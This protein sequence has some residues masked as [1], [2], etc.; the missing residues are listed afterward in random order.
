[1]EQSHFSYICKELCWRLSEVHGHTEP[2][3]GW[4]KLA[5]NYLGHASSVAVECEKRRTATWCA[6]LCATY[7]RIVSV[8]ISV[9]I[10]CVLQIRLQSLLHRGHP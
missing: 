9:I 6:S 2:F 3:L 8:A 7:M 1:M 10:F 5:T 4:A